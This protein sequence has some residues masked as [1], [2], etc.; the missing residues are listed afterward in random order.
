MGQTICTL[1]ELAG[2]HRM[3]PQ[4]REGDLPTPLTTP[5]Q[6]ADCPTAEPPARHTSDS[7]M[8][9]REQPPTATPTTET[10]PATK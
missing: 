3:E 10:A 8:R 1:L 4:C 6:R 7:P 5:D 9:H 2:P